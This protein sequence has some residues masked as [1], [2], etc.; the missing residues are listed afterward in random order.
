[1]FVI[2]IYDMIILPEVT[3]YFKQD[4][5]RELNL[6]EELKEDEEVVF[7]MLKEDR[8]RDEMRPEDF[9]PIGVSGKVEGIDSEGSVSVRTLGRV[10]VRAIQATPDMM[11]ADVEARS[12]EQDLDAEEAKLRFD[13][14]RTSM[15]KFIQRFQWGIWARSYVL[16]WKNVSEVVS[17]L[18]AYLNLTNEEKYAILETDSTRERFEKM[19]RSVYEFMEIARVGAVLFTAAR[20]ISC[21]CVS[22][23]NFLEVCVNNAVIT[24]TAVRV[25]AHIRVSTVKAC[26]TAHVRISTRLTAVLLVYLGGQCVECLLQV[27]GLCLDR[28]GIISAQ[29][30]SQVCDLALDCGLFVCRNL[31]AEFLQSVLALEAQALCVVLG[32]YFFTTL[33]VVFCILLCFL[34]SLVDVL[35]GHVGGSSDLDV[36]FLAG[37]QIL[38]SHVYDTVLVDVE[39]Y[40]DL[41]YL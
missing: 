25:A 35:L 18:S 10:D 36:L 23:L 14:L 27:V 31:V 16:H 15:L 4:V 26:G 6:Q 12:G 5:F 20:H 3:Y 22:F 19:E 11:T 41:R 21:R 38:C 40:F 28:C 32:I 29:C 17:A 8:N 2:P 34:D 33:L 24:G 9:F 13:K 39:C 7:L 37:A 1:M 30:T